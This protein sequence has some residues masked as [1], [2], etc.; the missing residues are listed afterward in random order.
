[1]AS[2]TTIKAREK[3]AKAHAEGKA[4]PKITHVGW[5]TG[6]VDSNGNVIAPS[7]SQTKVAGEFIK[8]P[9]DSVSYP[10][11][12]NGD[13]TVVRF[14]A[15]LSPTDSNALGKAVSSVGLYDQEGDLIAI[16]NFG[17]KLIDE[18]STDIEI[19]WDETF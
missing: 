9:I 7:P 19:V 4:V 13:Y 11:A 16:K 10:N 14:V 3:F 2:V 8:K 15:T 18:D 6:G 1:M 17:S 5:G 12:S